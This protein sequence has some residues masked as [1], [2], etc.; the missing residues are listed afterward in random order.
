MKFFLNK[1]AVYSLVIVSLFIVLGTAGI[2]YSMI[3]LNKELEGMNDKL[4]NELENERINSEQLS[5]DIERLGKEQKETAA[6]LEE[7]RSELIQA[8]VS[9]T[10]VDADNAILKEETKK[11]RK[12]LKEKQA[13]KV[14]APKSAVASVKTVSRGD[15]S[16]AG[17]W[18]YYNASAYTAKCAGCSGITKTGKNIRNQSIDHRVVAVDPTVIPLGS[19]VEVEGLGR[20]TALDTGGAIKGFKIDVLMQSKKQ[21][22]DFGRKPL[23]VR[24]IRSGY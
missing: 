11:L 13:A 9:K 22:Y 24:V 16:Q 2:M 10:Q 21:A 4:V 1:H 15:S 18:S 14:A 3:T 6:L 23:K 5:V 12:E 7:V 17:S 19:V 8:E 20:F